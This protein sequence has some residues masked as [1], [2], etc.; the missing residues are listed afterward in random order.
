MGGRA[1]ISPAL[2]PTGQFLIDVKRKALAE[3]GNGLAL[4]SCGM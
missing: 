1:I 2:E 4:E 3:I